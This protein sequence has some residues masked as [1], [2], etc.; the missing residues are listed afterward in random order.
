M[1][2]STTRHCSNSSSSNRGCPWVLSGATQRQQQQAQVGL[3]GQ[4]F[5]DQRPV[6]YTHLTLPTI[7]SV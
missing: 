5:A 4:L 2:S 7:C 6:S 3:V 1:E